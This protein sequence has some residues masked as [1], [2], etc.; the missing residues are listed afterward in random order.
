MYTNTKRPPAS[1]QL[2]CLS[3]SFPKLLCHTLYVKNLIH[4]AT[5]THTS[6][7]DQPVNV[8]N[9][10]LQIPGPHCVVISE[11]SMW[12]VLLHVKL[13][14][15]EGMR[16][17]S[18]AAF[19]CV[20]FGGTCLEASPPRSGCHMLLFQHQR[21]SVK[22]SVPRQ[23]SADLMLSNT[24]THPKALASHCSSLRFFVCQAQ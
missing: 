10:L 20:R 15:Q 24:S 1:P 7:Y 13:L 16:S 4:E 6:A 12:H 2:T 9:V 21:Q 5:G 17:L 8:K 11:R 3:L 22:S 14:E 23:S 19:L 18:E